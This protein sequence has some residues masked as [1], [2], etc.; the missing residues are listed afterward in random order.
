MF[1]PQAEPYKSTKFI[2]VIFTIEC[3][4]GTKWQLRRKLK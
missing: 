2:D 1:I 3:A 4:C